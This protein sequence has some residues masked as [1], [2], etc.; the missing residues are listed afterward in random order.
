MK[1]H[2]REAKGKKDRYVTLPNST[3]LALRD[4]WRTHRHPQFIFPRGKTI[5]QQRQADTVMDRGGLQKSFK[6][7]VNDVGIKKDITL[8]T[9]RHCYGTLLTEAGVALRSIQHEMG[10]ECPKTTA[11]YTQ[12]SKITAHD[13]DQQINGVMNK[14]RIC[15]GD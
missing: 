6:I 7:I 5:E 13:T 4:F 12:L 2:I 14:F 10:H 9:L 11:L 3:L 1:V 8:H 15:W